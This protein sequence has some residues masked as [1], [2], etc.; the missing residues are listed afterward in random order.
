MVGALLGPLLFEVGI[1][2]NGT[3]AAVFDVLALVT[4]LMF[5]RQD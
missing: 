4:L 1:L 2:A 5:V 3:A